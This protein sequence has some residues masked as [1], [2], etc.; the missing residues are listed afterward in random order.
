MSHDDLNAIKEKLQKLMAK[1]ESAKEIGSAAEAA[2][3][4]AKV[5]ELLTKYNLEMADIEFS[6]EDEVIADNEN[7]LVV[8]NKM[9]RWTSR[10]LGILCHY[11]YCK[12]IYYRY[13]RRKDMKV[14]L[15]GKK[16]NVEVVLF[17]YSILKS[18]LENIAK[19]EW[20]NYINGVQQ[21]LKNIDFGVGILQSNIEAKPWMYIKSVMNRQSFYKSFFLGAVSGVNQKLEEE[22]KKSEI[23]YGDKITALVKINDAQIINFVKEHYNNLG[24]F[25]SKTIRINGNAYNKGVEAGKNA[26]MARGIST[27]DRIA[28]KLLN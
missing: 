26:S 4:S 2:T 23:V 16:E 28:T 20:K 11:N 25:K 3:F 10:L 15:I 27:G 21:Q 14:T 12:D 17:L 24:T 1:A 5:N 19:K 13:G 22:I 9:G 8:M 7:G 6:E 18:Q